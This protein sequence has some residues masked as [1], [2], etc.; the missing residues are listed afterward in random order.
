MYMLGASDVLVALLAVL[1]K[2]V[3]VALLA[4]SMLG[5]SAINAI[6]CV[7]MILE[8]A[9]D[10]RALVSVRVLR[11]SAGHTDNGA[12]VCGSGILIPFSVN[13]NIMICISAAK[14]A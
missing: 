5:L 4:V 6:G 7:S 13:V 2:L 10:T 1:V 3:I 14:P 9:V 8:S 12:V 11:K